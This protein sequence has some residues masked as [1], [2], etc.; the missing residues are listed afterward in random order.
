MIYLKKN[1]IPRGAKLSLKTVNILLVRINHEYFI[2]TKRKYL[3]L[4]QKSSKYRIRNYLPFNCYFTQMKNK[5]E[6]FYLF[7]QITC[8]KS[9]FLNLCSAE[10]FCSAAANLVFRGMIKK[11]KNILAH[12]REIKIFSFFLILLRNKQTRSLRR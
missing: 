8:Y 12:I 7:F 1:Q 2:K 5:S 3:F 10:H 6:N 9:G 11:I 4:K